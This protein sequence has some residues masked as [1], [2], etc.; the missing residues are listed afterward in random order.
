[1]NK[2]ILIG[3]LGRDPEMSYTPNGL[4]VTKFSL[5]VTRNEKNADGEKIKETDWYNVTAFGTLAEISND[6]LKKGNRV[7]AEG[8]IAQRKYH[9]RH[10]VERIS[11]D[12]ILSELENLTP[13]ERTGGVEGSDEERGAL[14]DLENHPF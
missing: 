14:G 6:Y 13:R 8:R 3:N 11:L 2:I 1:M 7:Y 10:G 9:D 5:A 12:V 4:A